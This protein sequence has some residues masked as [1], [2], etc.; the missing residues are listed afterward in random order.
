MDTRTEV[1]AD[2]IRLTYLNMTL[3]PWRL[4][5][6]LMADLGLSEAK[7][8]DVVATLVEREENA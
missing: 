6:V 3:T 4:V 1:E 8:R 2:E 5:E 7:A